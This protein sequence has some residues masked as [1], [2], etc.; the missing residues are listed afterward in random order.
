MFFYEMAPDEDFGSYDIAQ[1]FA[2]ALIEA[3]LETTCSDKQISEAANLA[4]ECPDMDLAAAFC[5]QLW[6]SGE[7]PF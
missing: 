5:A 1:G 4:A 6:A 7:S 3:D 2:V